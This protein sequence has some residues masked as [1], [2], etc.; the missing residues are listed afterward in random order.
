MAPRA[1][2]LIISVGAAFIILQRDE[3]CDLG[4]D[5]S[6]SWGMWIFPKISSKFRSASFRDAGGD[7]L[8]AFP[9]KRDNVV[10]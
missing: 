4:L 7:E 9:F 1:V 10:V 5:I 2:A 3:G 8:D 6:L